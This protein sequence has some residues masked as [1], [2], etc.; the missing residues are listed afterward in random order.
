MTDGSDDKIE[1]QIRKAGLPTT[2]AA[3]F[4]PLL[5]TNRRGESMIQK[6]RIDEGPKRGKIGYVDV[7]GR[8]WVK[9]YAHAEYPDHWDVQTDGGS[10]Y[11]RVDFQGNVLP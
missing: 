6:A 1:L 5:T 8:I 3:P 7:Q 11:I 2:G 9:D 4:L 10:G